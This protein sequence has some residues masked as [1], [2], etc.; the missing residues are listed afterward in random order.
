M[1]DTDR[2]DKAM[3]YLAETDKPY[4]KARAYMLGLEK[5][6]KT[7]I[8][9]KILEQKGKDGTVG[10]KE[11]LARTSHEYKCWRED[12]ENAVADYETYRNRRHTADL[13]IEVWRSEFSAKKQGI[14]V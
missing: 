6:E 12:Y 5:Q 14:I 13:V 2:R 4:A 9:L 7:I 11:A 1:I 10:E 3:A 8:G